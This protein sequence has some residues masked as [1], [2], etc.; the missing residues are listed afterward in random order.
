MDNREAR[1]C[2][3]D[4]HSGHGMGWFVREEKCDMF[5]DL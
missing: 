1:A 3:E 4:K 2:N 5:V